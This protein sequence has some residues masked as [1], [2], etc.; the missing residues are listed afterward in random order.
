MIFHSVYS[1][2]YYYFYFTL[3]EILEYLEDFE[4][5]DVFELLDFT[6][7]FNIKFISESQSSCD[8]TTFDSYLLSI[9][10]F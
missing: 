2:Y 9:L 6:S 8:L 3:F 7:L 5:L 4:I 10:Y 1:I